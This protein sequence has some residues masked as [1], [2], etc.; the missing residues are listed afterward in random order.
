[1]GQVAGQAVEPASHTVERIKT[2]AFQLS[3]AEKLGNQAWIADLHGS[4]NATGKYISLQLVKATLSGASP[5]IE[6]KTTGESPEFAKKIANAL[7]IELVNRQD[8]IAKP[9]ID[10]MRLDLAIA[11]EK[12]V[13]VEKELDGINKL[14]ANV[15]IKDDRFTQLSLMTTLG[16]Q[17]R[18]ELFAQRQTISALETAL[19]APATQSAKAIEEVFV[20]ER[21]V[22]PKKGLLVTLGVIG[23]LLAGVMSVFVKD[24][25][26]RAKEKR[27]L[28]ASAC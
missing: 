28:A 14:V 15:G 6:L 18:S 22:S 27:T 24:A 10:K 4:A 11:K 9:L 1:V 19:M 13:S 5:L 8:E 21:P 20:T 26:R 23:G 17:K 16:L 25:V 2:S 3:V 7:V 12:L